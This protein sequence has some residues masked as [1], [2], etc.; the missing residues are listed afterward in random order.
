MTETI[1]TN[2]ARQGREGRPVLG[3][4]QISLL[5]AAFVGVGLFFWMWVSDEQT[6]LDA[7]V[8]AP[9]GVTEPAAPSTGTAAP[10]TPSEPASPA[11]PAN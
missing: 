11:A 3:V 8:T 5:L 10:A 6:G 7:G 2:D 4:L 9:A 1:K